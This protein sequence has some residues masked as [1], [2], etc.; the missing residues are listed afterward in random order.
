M[1]PPVGARRIVSAGG[2][3]I[4]EKPIETVVMHSETPAAVVPASTTRV[5]YVPKRTGDQLTD[6]YG[7]E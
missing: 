3:V 5:L 7:G 4:V 6:L 1:H 2:Y